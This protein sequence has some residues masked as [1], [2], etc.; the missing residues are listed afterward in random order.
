[1]SSTKQTAE[2]TSIGRAE[3]ERMNRPLREVDPEVADILELE[4]RRQATGLE[5]IP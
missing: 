4:A 1:M 2:Q 3:L 5:L